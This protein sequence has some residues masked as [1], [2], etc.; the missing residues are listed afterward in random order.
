MGDVAVCCAGVRAH[1]CT[2]I[3]VAQEGVMA[4]I[5]NNFYQVLASAD[6]EEAKAQGFREYILA[7]HFY[8]YMY[9]VRCV[10]SSMGNP[11][12]F[13]LFGENRPGLC[14]ITLRH[15]APQVRVLSMN[16]SDELE[17]FHGS[18]EECLT[19]IKDDDSC[20]PW[21]NFGG[22]FAASDEQVARSHGNVMYKITPA[23]ALTDY[24]LNYSGELAAYS[25][26]MRLAND[27]EELADAIMSRACPAACEMDGLEVQRLRGQLARE[28][29]FDAVEMEDEH[30][31]TW[32]CLPGCQ[33]ER[34]GE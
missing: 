1:A 21:F 34:V 27:S 5:L 24:E 22:L 7:K 6:V 17:L 26:A 4:T 18:S 30:G 28:L 8:Q 15:N 33:I 31:T 19:E 11:A 10:N 2:R 3:L 20:S 16:S 32:L 14:R 25:Y 12:S 23:R 29:G 9:G 13:L